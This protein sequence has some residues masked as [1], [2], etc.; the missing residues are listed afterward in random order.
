MKEGDR[1]KGWE[2]SRRGR[3]RGGKLGDRG[4]MEAGRQRD[5]EVEAGRRR[6]REGEAGR[7]EGGGDEKSTVNQARDREHLG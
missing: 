7:A 1:G 4:E 3:G 6:P 2:G 5:G